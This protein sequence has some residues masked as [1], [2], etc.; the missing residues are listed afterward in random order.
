MTAGDVYRGQQL[1]GRL[2]RLANGIRFSVIE[3]IRLPYGWV[4]TS[5]PC[6]TDDFSELPNFFLNLLPEGARLQLLLDSAR[7][8]DDALELL[9]RVGWDTIGD[10][11]VLPSGQALGE[12][13]ANVAVKD[14]GQVS[15]WELF[16]SGTSDNADS[17]IPGAQEKVSAATVAFGVR[18]K[19]IPSAILKLNPRQ[20]PLLVQNEAFFLRMA[21]G[22]RIEVNRA[23]VVHDRDGEPGLL[24]QRFDRKD[25]GAEKL[26]QEDGCQLLDSPPA[27]KY[28]P[29][30]RAI[31][32]RVAETC[33]SPMVEVERL[34]RLTAF[35]YIIGNG[36]LHAKNV[37]VLW[38]EVVRLS[39]GYDLLSTLPYKQLDQ[40]LAL[41][42]Q[43][44]ND[45]LLCGD[46]ID[47]GRIYGLTETATRRMIEELCDLAEPWLAR[48]AEIGFDP[49]VTESLQSEMARRLAKLQR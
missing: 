31:A 37:S 29:S 21:K 8:R 16:R 36:D 42:L 24:V 39:P 30:M 27:N 28:Q 10:I 12:R 46:F 5:L 32:D 11:A 13:R 47:F 14:L 41:F 40:H 49:R 19:G 17:A 1:I 26:H 3:G 34:M 35:S 2:E 33:S 25:R 48:V 23:K 9:L 44:K 45:N 22:C 6:K 18:A 43:G 38:D 15:F 7:S 4:A 20:F